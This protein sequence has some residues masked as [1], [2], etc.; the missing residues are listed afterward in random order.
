MPAVDSQYVAV[1]LG[2]LDRSMAQQLADVFKGPAVKQQ[3]D[4][5]G[6]PK[7]M[8]TDTK[9]RPAQLLNGFFN[10][11]GHRLSAHRKNPFRLSK[12]ARVQI[13]V[14]AVLQ[15]VIGY[16]YVALG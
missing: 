13:T 7:G 8:S 1:D 2:T 5:K 11:T 4:R 10:T 15:C 6:M 3:V 12:M 16:R 9:G 14:N